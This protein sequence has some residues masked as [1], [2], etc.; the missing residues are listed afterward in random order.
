MGAVMI[1][2]YCLICG[3][4][5]SEEF[6]E[7]FFTDGSDTIGMVGREIGEYELRDRTDGTFD[8]E[9]FGPEDFAGE[10]AGSQADQGFENGIPEQR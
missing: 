5:F 1:G 6:M 4:F 10:P 8:R 2:M 3:L 9:F 7:Q